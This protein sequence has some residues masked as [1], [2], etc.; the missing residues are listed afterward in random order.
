MI[1]LSFVGLVGAAETAIWEPGKVI[2]V[3]QVSTPAKTPDP[4]C[5]SVPKG[6]DPPA[7]CRASNLRA[8]QFWRV[9]LEVGNKRL[10]VRPYRSPKLIDALS[11]D[12][13]V[14]IDPNLTPASSVEVA[15]F[16]SK[17]IRLRAD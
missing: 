12:R 16:S 5:R 13:A 14:Y 6:E 15:L 7:R 4:T 9:T 8:E 2:A 11:Q 17:A 3:E 10:V 1:L